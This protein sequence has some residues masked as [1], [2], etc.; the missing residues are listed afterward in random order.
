MKHTKFFVRKII[1]L[2]AAI[3]ISSFSSYAQTSD[4][5]TWTNS[6]K[7]WASIDFIKFKK[8]LTAATG[9]SQ[10]ELALFFSY[11]EERFRGEKI[12]FFY[13]ADQGLINEEN[14]G[15]Y[16]QSLS[17]IFINEYPNFLKVKDVYDPDQGSIRPQAANGP[18]ENVGFE[19]GTFS[20]WTGFVGEHCITNGV[21]G[22]CNPIN[23]FAQH[24]IMSTGM[25]D[26][27][28]PA[29]SVLAPGSNYSLRLGNT[30]NG[31]QAAGI[32][33]VFK[34]DSSN[35][36][37]IYRYAVVLE[38]P[39]DHTDPERPYFTAKLYDQNMNEILCAN[40][41][42][43]VQSNLN[44]FN[45]LCVNDP[46]GSRGGG[47]G[48]SGTPTTYVGTN[49]GCP[50][51]A[52][53]YDGSSTNISSGNNLPVNGACSSSQLDIYWKNWTTVSIPLNAYFGQNVTVEF[54]AADCEPSG[55]LGY[56]YLDGECLPQKIISVGTPVCV[57]RNQTA[58][59]S[60]PQGFS[61][62]QWTG[63]ASGIVGP[64]NT[65]NI[66]ASRPGVYTVV[67][68]PLNN[69]GPTAVCTVT[70][71]FTVIENCALPVE[72]IA[73][74]AQQNSANSVRLQWLTASEKNNLLFEVQRS[75]DGMDW[76]K[77]GSV[78]GNGTS[79]IS[80]AYSFLDLNLSERQYYY[81]L[82]QVD[83]D[84]NSSFS[85]VVAVSVDNEMEVVPSFINAGE[86]IKIM[87][88]LNQEI[89]GSLFNMNGQLLQYIQSGKNAIELSGEGLHPGIYIVKLVSSSGAI[90]KK[91]LVY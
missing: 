58:T 65:Q 76:V 13:N 80:S 21:S 39:Q 42:V 71:N 60:A 9:I 37:Y 29:L 78:R 7:L 51:G 86:N 59:L 83:N 5:A 52:V 66:T 46:G 22:V 27:L 88:P 43:I 79:N 82:R 19:S 23:G 11:M 6:E 18:C 55:H 45:R 34:V 81:R 4:T 25:V 75:A 16:V 24:C 72:L 1:V 87:N 10:A 84:G 20:G 64:S 70:I 48:G 41:T 44:G 62:Y 35:L 53:G 77:I 8:D 14:L 17:D 69:S 90:T 2:F 50:S 36:L 32:R 3:L 15:A 38:D 49:R 33:Q 47:G 31:G 68:T 26:P 89:C 54:I 30:V 67:L 12:N 73:F 28:V 57:V 63:P 74:T 40:Y 91:I 56:A 85:I 61:T